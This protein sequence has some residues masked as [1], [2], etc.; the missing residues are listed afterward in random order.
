MTPQLLTVRDNERE[1][2]P[3]A[4]GHADQ[5]NHRPLATRKRPLFTEKE[6]SWSEFTALTYFVVKLHTRA[7]L[8]GVNQPMEMWPRQQ[9]PRS[10]S[11]G[12]RERQERPL[13][14][15]KGRTPTQA[16]KA[17]GCHCSAHLVQAGPSHPPP[18]AGSRAGVGQ[19]AAPLAHWVPRPRESATLVLG[20][21]GSELV[22]LLSKG[23][24]PFHSRSTQHPPLQA[25]CG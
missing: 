6:V 18:P 20:L 5:I 22:P 23:Q 7:K 3:H 1:T 9:M 10:I 17:G 14:V 11:P 19:P 2:P 24:R 25:S 4:L 8:S 12:F 13:P 16:P 21:S 15:P